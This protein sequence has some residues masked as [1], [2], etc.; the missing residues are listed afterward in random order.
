MN[1]GFAPRGLQ[2]Q[3]LDTARLLCFNQEL[4]PTASLQWRAFRQDRHPLNAECTARAPDITFRGHDLPF[5]QRAT[6]VRLLSADAEWFSG[7]CNAGPGHA[8]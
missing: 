8:L 2:G 1:P 3:S 6:H 7:L 5:P 4:I